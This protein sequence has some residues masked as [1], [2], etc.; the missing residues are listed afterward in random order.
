MP[1]D[2]SILA[3][4]ALLALPSILERSEHS[5]CV[6]HCQAGHPNWIEDKVD[7]EVWRE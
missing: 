4:M 1:V 3:H 7:D 6:S 5:A 2:S